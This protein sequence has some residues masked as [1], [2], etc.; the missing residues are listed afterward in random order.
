MKRLVLYSLLIIL[1][2]SA[3]I[4]CCA[5]WKVWFVSPP[6]PAWTDDTIHFRFRTFA[7]DSVNGFI[8]QNDVYVNTV[9]PDTLTFIVLGDV[10]NGIDSA[11]WEHIWGRHGHIDFY[12]QVG[13]FIDRGYFYYYELLV[14]EICNTPFAALPSIVTPGN[15]EYTKGMIKRLPPQWTED[16]W[17][18]PQNGPKRYEGTT[19]YVDFHNLR[20]IAIDTNG[21]QKLSDYTVV[22]TWLN[23]V[24]ADA[25]DRFKIVIMHHPVYS[26]AYG[27]SNPGE[28]MAFRLAL[29][30]AD[31]VFSG[32]D[33]NY[34]RSLP[35]VGI[36][37]TTKQKLSKVSNRFDRI[38][39]G[40]Q[41]YELCTLVADTLTV[42]TFLMNG[43]ELYDEFRVVCSTDSSN[44]KTHQYIVAEPTMGEIVELPDKYVGKEKSF[45]V[46][47]FH[48]RLAK[49]K[50]ERKY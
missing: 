17:H 21:L 26:G 33:H 41:M 37:S 2:T 9:S 35:Y 19:Y 30:E 3:T 28:F 47:V 7:D 16:W 29:N 20:F 49:R 12:A 34:Y 4:L 5:R 45:K 50:E 44:I 22:L 6:E 10:H 36:T 25:G 42:Q 18:N 48:R 1:L 40:R 38:C 27:R 23:K 13:D 39:S 31:V 32:H 24:I 46:K 11:S 14:K 15:H 43:G 8:R